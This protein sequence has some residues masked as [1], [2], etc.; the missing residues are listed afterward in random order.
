M[1]TTLGQESSGT[2][3][4]E[5]SLDPWSPEAMA[6]DRIHDLVVDLIPDEETR[7]GRSMG[8]HVIDGA[9]PHADVGKYVE[10]KVFEKRFRNDLD[11]MREAYSPYD[12]SSVF[13]IILDYEKEQ[14][15]A[16]VRVIKPDSPTGLKSTKDI[17]NP[18]TEKNPWYNPTDTE[19]K[20][21]EE[22]GDHDQQH[23]LDISTMAVMPEYRRNHGEE[24]A[25]AVLYSSCV[26]WSLENGYNYWITIV[27][28]RILGQMQEWGEPFLEFE[29]KGEFRP[30]MGSKASKPMHSELYS[31]LKKVKA[32]D[33]AHNKD[34]HG[35]YTKGRGLENAF[36]LP[37]F[38]LPENV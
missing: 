1:T 16:V 20:I 38:T 17:T 22:I 27:D 9:D 8:L 28:E 15:A 31:G 7:A 13:L 5:Q 35:L 36:V 26:R 6:D 33:L 30:F 23:T 25:S 24:S 37:E 21:L 11:E 3:S 12:G 14:P 18:D 10:W 4:H 29:G 19:A 2:S 32:Y 34:I